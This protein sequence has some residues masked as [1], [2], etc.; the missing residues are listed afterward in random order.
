MTVYADVLFL[1]NFSMDFLTL[2]FTGKVLSKPMKTVRLCLSASIG[3]LVGTSATVLVDSAALFANIVL[4][5]AGFAL[6]AVMML[7]AFGKYIS[8]L[9]LLRDSVIL[10]GSGALLGGVMTALLSLGEPV[11]VGHGGGGVFAEAFVV[12][13]AVSSV[14]VRLFSSGRAKK[15]CT[16][17]FTAAGEC[18]TFSALTDS[19]NLLREPISSLPVVIVSH[20]AVSQFALVPDRESNLHVRLI[21]MKSVGGERLLYGFLPDII[22]VDGAEVRAVVA[23]DNENNS[24]GDCAGIVPQSLVGR[25]TIKRRSIKK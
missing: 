18:V 25:E 11:F 2:Y 23:V 22:T 7:V 16:V 15:F 13:F 19:G 5:V 1:I 9:S 8:V 10:W 14:V 24:F 4:S 3:A 21:P 20:T 6:S 12:C 17:S